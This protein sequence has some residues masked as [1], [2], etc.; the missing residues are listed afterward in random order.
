MI[1][2]RYHIV[3]MIAVFLALGMGI[4]V[5]TTVIDRVTVEALTRQQRSLDSTNERLRQEVEAL[6]DQNSALSQFAT[7]VANDLI[8]GA[9]RDVPVL[10]IASG[11]VSDDIAD[12]LGATLRVAGARI[13]GFF[14]LSERLDLETEPR[15]QQ[16]ALALQV[17]TTEATVLRQQLIDRLTET[18]AGRRTGLLQRLIDSGLVAARQLEGVA[19]HPPADVPQAGTAVVVL[20]GTVRQGMKLTESFMLPLVEGLSASGVLVVACEENGEEQ[21]LVG[22]LRQRPPGRLVTV[23]GIE[24]PVGLAAVALGLQAALEGNFGHWGTGDGSAGV[25]PPRRSPGA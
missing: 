1:N 24:S 16:V 8:R 21:P 19:T 4:L 22:P 2:F 15:R 20:G 11:D 12:S 25:L 3:S 6:E 5:G 10:V 14:E 23:G 7:L 17:E 18:L 9:L 13:D